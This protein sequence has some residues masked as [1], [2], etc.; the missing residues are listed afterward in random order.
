MA[1]ILWSLRNENTEDKLHRR[2]LGVEYSRAELSKLLGQINMPYR[3]WD[4]Q[5]A[6]L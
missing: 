4:M 6:C 3:W 1:M 2:L 5:E